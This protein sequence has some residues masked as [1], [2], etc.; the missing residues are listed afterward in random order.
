MSKLPSY[1]VREWHP[2]KNEDLKPEDVTAKSRK[3][4]WWMCNSG[5]GWKATVF[6]RYKGHGCPYDSG[7]RISKALEFAKEWHPTKNGDLEFEDV[8]VSYHKKVWWMCAC[9]HEW[10]ATVSNR[11]KGHGC[12]FDPVKLQW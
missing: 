8:I 4:V 10:E 9:G 11:I 5:H 6:N 12:Q 3:K 7:R 1:L 2:T